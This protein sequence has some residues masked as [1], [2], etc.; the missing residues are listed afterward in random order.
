MNRSPRGPRLLALGLVL[1]CAACIKS[2]PVM[3]PQPVAAPAVPIG[4]L[5]ADSTRLSYLRA[6]QLVRLAD[7]LGAGALVSTAAA[8][9][10]DPRA[11]DPERPLVVVFG[12]PP[13]GAIEK[14]AIS[15]LLPIPPG[16]SLAQTLSAMLGG[17]RVSRHGEGVA[18]A[19]NQEP[20][21]A[22]HGGAL[23]DQLAAAPLP[24]DIQVQFN[25]AAVMARTGDQ[26][27]RTL[28]EVQNEY[29]KK[30]RA[31]GQTGTA[32]LLG[33]Y[34]NWLE[35]SLQ[36]LQ[37]VTF[38]LGA[39]EA[40]L[41]L[42][43]VMADKPAAGATAPPAQVQAIA[44]L[45][46]FVPAGDIRLETASNGETAA[47]RMSLQLYQEI[48]R[49]EPQTL[50][51]FKQATAVMSRGRTQ[52][53]ASLRFG[54]EH[55]VSGTAILL[56]DE[57]EQKFD[58]LRRLLD[59]SGSPALKRFYE[60]AGLSVHTT[61]ARAARSVAGWPVD[62]VTVQIKPGAAAAARDLGEVGRL[63]A[64]PI[65]LDVMRIGSYLVYQVNGTPE[66]YARVVSDL[67]TGHGPHGS[68]AARAQHPAGGTL[69][70]DVDVP[71]L[72][73]SLGDLVPRERRGEW[74][75]LE[76]SIPQITAFGYQGGPIG[77]YRMAVP[78]DLIKAVREAASRTSRA[79]PSHLPQPK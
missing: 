27:H 22:A 35:G 69:Y 12:D 36:R 55:L 45:A 26:L 37:S 2:P 19:L 34:I 61:V 15:A 18:I 47:T 68:L 54:G 51:R 50:E 65:E 17:Q 62:H 21:D 1:C 3:H 4:P 42:S 16:G 72:L 20:V 63:L 52:Y 59:L 6:H 77:Y 24:A 73:A 40:S 43:M 76:P 70:A 31:G 78:A 30:A 10:L 66:S 74:P 75:K 33:A 79:P 56:A 32:G 60:G 38:N 53:A 71:R 7:R 64:R 57:A 23:L 14:T 29:E 41:D 11:L 8:R 13:E 9:G 25:M 67:L 44:G 46:E 39:G 58:A 48:L 49:S 28:V 5:P